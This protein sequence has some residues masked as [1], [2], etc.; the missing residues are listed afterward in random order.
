MGINLN[1]SYVKVPGADELDYELS[2]INLNTSYVKVP[3]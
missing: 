3:V 2:N 1:T